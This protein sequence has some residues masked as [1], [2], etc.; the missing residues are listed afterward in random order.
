MRQFVADFVSC[1]SAKYYLNWFTVGKD[2]TKISVNFLLRSSVESLATTYN[3]AT[4]K[5]TKQ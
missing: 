2:I 5:K 4:N 3:R 1:V